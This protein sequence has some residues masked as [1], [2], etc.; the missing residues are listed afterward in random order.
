MLQGKSKFVP[1]LSSFVD[2]ILLVLAFVVARIYVFEGYPPDRTLYIILGVGCLLLWIIIAVKME[3]YELPRIL[4]IDKI[5]SRNL[6]AIMVFTFL[7]G[8]LVFFLTDY[9]Y[10]RFFFGSTIIV[11]YSI[12]TFVENHIHNIS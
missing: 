1:L 6:L 8:G 4:H 11:F 5:L 2:I 7:S 12:L 10:S 3:L 9:K